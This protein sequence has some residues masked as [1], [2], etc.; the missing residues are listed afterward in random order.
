[1]GTYYVHPVGDR[2]R[3][4]CYGDIYTRDTCGVVR[5]LV[6]YSWSWV[7]GSAWWQG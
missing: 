7:L 3:L 2:E 6:G 4:I 5:R 1:M